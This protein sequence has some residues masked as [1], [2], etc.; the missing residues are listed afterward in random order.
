[1]T[2]DV[3]VLLSRTVGEDGCGDSCVTVGVEVRL[4]LLL[5]LS[6]VD[7]ALEVDAAVLGDFGLTNRLFAS[8]VG[9]W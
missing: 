1:M 5:S 2:A 4:G 8:S 6:C 9:V 7:P 3:G